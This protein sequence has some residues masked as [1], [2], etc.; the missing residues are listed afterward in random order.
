ML[1]KEDN[2]LLCST[3]AGTPMGELFRRYWHPVLLARELPAPDGPPKR[4]RVLGEDLVAFRDTTGRI[5][6]VQ[7]AC[8][9]RRAGLF[10]GRNEENGLRCVYHGWKFDVTGG[11]I[12][13]PS[14]PEASN[15]KDK[16]RIKTYPAEE[17]G[18][19]IWLY[20][21]P[22]ELKPELPKFEWA[23][24][25][26]NQRAVS[27]WLQRSNYMQAVEGEIDSAHVSWLHGS[28]TVE[29]SPFAGRFRNAILTDGTPKLAVRET[30]YGLTYGARRK[31]DE[32]GFYWR[33]TQW[34]LPTY[35]LIPSAIFPRGGRAWIPIDDEHISVI[36]YGYHADRAMTDEELLRTTGTPQVEPAEYRLPDGG[37]IDTFLDVRRPENDYLIDREMQKNLNFTG[38]SVIRSQDTA[39]TESMGA[40][41]EREFEHL[42]TTDL[43][44]I[45]ARRKLLRLARE[46]MESIEPTDSMDPD[47][48][49]V[50][51]LDLHCPEPDFDRLTEQ[52]A[53]ETQAVW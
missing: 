50:R 8:P 22:P 44:V 17:Y 3:N 11:C 21:G 20:M 39:M 27:R 26:E 40:I 47:I 46:L 19:C 49:R 1:S 43:A 36:Q 10:W 42:G 12:D 25:P 29:N 16:I 48:Y 6:V 5:G 2:A 14:E 41:E 35:S 38:I 33:V 37:R 32:G 24:V 7:S 45:V 52:F 4:L 23:V 31:D 15:F 30:P 9:H 18:S 13:M 53:E 34:M 28:L 51:S